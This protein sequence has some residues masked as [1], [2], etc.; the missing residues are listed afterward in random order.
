MFESLME[1]S[2][3]SIDEAQFKGKT[4]FYAL[5]SGGKDSITACHVAMK[6]VKLEG[7]IMVDTTIAIKETHDHVKK[8]AQQFQLPLIILKQE[9]N[10]FPTRKSSLSSAFLQNWKVK[11]STDFL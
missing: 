6:F 7:I 11:K 3:K 4:K 5:V 10:S 2:K 8:I 1:S 9:S